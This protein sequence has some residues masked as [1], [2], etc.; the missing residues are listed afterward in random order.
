MTKV[1]TYNQDTINQ[2]RDDMFQ[3]QMETIMRQESLALDFS[4]KIKVV[5]PKVPGCVPWYDVR[6][7]SSWVSHV[8]F[9]EN[10][11]SRIWFRTNSGRV[12]SAQ[13]ISLDLATML[14]EVLNDLNSQSIGKFI[15]VLK[16]EFEVAIRFEFISGD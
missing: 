13:A 3:L 2:L 9:T 7:Y 12:Y 11:S 15:N 16:K 14:K 8:T 4:S 1:L 5:L 6:A 10:H